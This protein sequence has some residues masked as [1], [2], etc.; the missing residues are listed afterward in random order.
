MFTILA[1]VLTTGNILI[2]GN[3]G[4]GAT[5][6]KMEALKSVAVRIL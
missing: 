2:E 4:D 3:D 6:N 1:G 5:I